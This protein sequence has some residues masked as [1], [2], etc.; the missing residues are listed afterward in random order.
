V[1][2]EQACRH[3]GEFIVRG[4]AL[5][6]HERACANGGSERRRRSRYREMFFAANG[7]GPY[8]CWFCG[9]E[10]TFALVVV[11]HI[12]GDHTNDVVSNL[13]AAHRSCHNGHHFKELWAERRDEM[14]QKLSERPRNPWSEE[15]KKRMSEHHKAAGHR[16]SPEAVAKAIELNR[17]ST[18]SPEVRKNIS[19]GR[20]RAAEKRREG[21][22]AL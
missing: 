8:A 2:R 11:H 13:T 21:G 17:G 10:V 16:P 22:G 19:E 20:K 5:A 18:R 14:S 7:M 3:C 15:A 4:G 1:T 6:S 12:D 9:G